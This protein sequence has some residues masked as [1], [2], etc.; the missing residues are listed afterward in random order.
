MRVVRVL[1]LLIGSSG[2][3]APAAA[4]ATVTCAAGFRAMGS[5]PGGEWT[6][7]E[8]TARRDGGLVFTHSNG[9]TIAFEKTAEALFGCNGA[10]PT[11]NATAG[12]SMMDNPTYLEQ[13]GGAEPSYS[14]MKGFLPPMICESLGLCGSPGVGLALAPA[15]T[16]LCVL[17]LL[18]QT[19]R[20]PCCL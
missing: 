4:S 7:C 8:A 6:V 2:S 16:T 12:C 13:L 3:A 11:K 5:T 20:T 1:A 19:P 17:L 14:V 15:P 9:T 10:S 18:T